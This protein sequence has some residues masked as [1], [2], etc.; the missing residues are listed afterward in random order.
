MLKVIYRLSLAFVVVFLLTG[1][2]AVAKTEIKVES[3][4]DTSIKT[5]ITFKDEAAAELKN[6]DSLAQQV[7]S[8]ISEK[9]GSSVQKTS[10]G[11]SL[12]YLASI[13]YSQLISPEISQLTGISDISIN[14]QE[15]NSDLRVNLTLSSPEA[16]KAAIGAQINPG[17]SETLLAGTAVEVVVS[18][19][20]AV[21][22]TLGNIEVTRDGSKATIS[23]PL[24]SFNSGTIAIVGS[25]DKP[26][27][28]TILIIPL[29]V[30]LG[31]LGVLKII[32]K[33]Q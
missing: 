29:V 4:T 14:S 32:S 5:G 27:N 12:T 2:Q 1:C 22:S 10:S 26:F 33:R 3:A 16:L 24:E 28:Y 21:K 7:E 30:L 11:S 23:Q 17:T 9:T 8:F 18:F 31:I 20:G 15:N 25:T 13:D 19:P 6:N